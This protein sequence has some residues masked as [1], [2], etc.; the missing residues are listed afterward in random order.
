MHKMNTIIVLMLAI[1]KCFEYIIM[2][3][4]IKYYVYINI[5]IEK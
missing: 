4:Y 1:N 3:E 5:S 2:Y